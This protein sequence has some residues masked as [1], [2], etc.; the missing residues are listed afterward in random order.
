[1][2]G[3]IRS[4]VIFWFWF[5]CCFFCVFFL[6]FS[7][8][9]W[10]LFLSSCFF[11]DSVFDCVFCFFAKI[12]FL[13]STRGHKPS[14]MDCNFWVFMAPNMIR[15]FSDFVLLHATPRNCECYLWLPPSAS[16][17][18]YHPIID[19]LSWL[20]SI[21]AWWIIMPPKESH[22]ISR[23]TSHWY[24][25][26]LLVILQVSPLWVVTTCSNH[27]AFQTFKK[28]SAR[29]T[30]P[31]IPETRA[32]PPYSSSGPPKG[33]WYSPKT[34]WPV[35]LAALHRHAEIHL[36]PLRKHLCTSKFAIYGRSGVRMEEMTS[37]SVFKQVHASIQ[38]LLVVLR[39]SARALIA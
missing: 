19:L 16:S 8:F 28:T 31:R 36:D 30:K 6:V 38:F 12:H 35:P 20:T 14:H 25:Q 13:C 4:E 22:I 33:R 15:L 11:G 27:G 7:W 37:L 9:F 1:M 10:W 29:A 2:V 17:I 39:G 21:S 32:W 34:S 3:I 5:Y 23:G 24:P 26:V 18:R